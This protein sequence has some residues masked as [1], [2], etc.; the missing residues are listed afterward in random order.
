MPPS[1]LRESPREETATSI[2]SPVSANE[3]RVPVIITAAVL[4]AFRSLSATFTLKFFKV[5]TNAWRVARLR[6]LS[7]LP[8][9][10]TTRP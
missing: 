6:S 4:R 10:P 2:L 5:L 7:P 1:R 8:A 3:R 9:R